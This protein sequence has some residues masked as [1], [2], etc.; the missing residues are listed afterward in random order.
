MAFD[1]SSKLPSQHRHN[2]LFR[3]NLMNVML[4]YVMI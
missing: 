4:C 3:R 2:K 1:F